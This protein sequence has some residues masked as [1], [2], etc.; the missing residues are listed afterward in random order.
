MNIGIIGGGVAGLTAAYE[1]TRKGHKVS[2]FEASPY[3]GGQAA[4]FEVGGGRLEKAYHHLFKSD[5]VIIDLIN[6][7][8]LG[9]KLYWLDSKVGFYCKERIHN[10][11]TPFD[12]L[13]FTPISIV[14]RLRLGLVSL[15]LQRLNDW[16]KLEG[17]TA[18][19]WII[20]YAGKQNYDMVWGPL[21]RGKFGD[22]AEEVGMVW[23]WG[24][25]HLRF[26]SRGKTM[27]KEKLGYLMGSFGQVIDALEQEIRKRGGEIHI[28][29]P[30]Q[31]IAVADGRVMGLELKASSN[32][33]PFDAVIATVPSPI[34]LRL[35]PELPEQY[36]SKL[37]QIKYQAAVL[38]V[39]LLKRSLSHIYWLNVS[40][41]A[42]P[43]LAAI[44]HTNY[45]GRSE[46]GGKHIVYLSNYLAREHPIYNKSGDELLQ[47]YL[48][49]LRKLNPEFSPDWI[50]KYYYH[51]ED[52]AQPIITT[53]YS[54]KIPDYRT[55]IQG[56]YLANTTQ[57][58]PEDRGMNYSIRLGQRVSGIVAPG[59]ER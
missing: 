31:R 47:I 42:L 52:S 45:I 34:F 56:L 59:L 1:L 9:S 39:L 8:G 37:R 38:V 55:P 48:P 12:L 4:T 24:K 3:L 19:D 18:K 11:V 21:L 58:Y 30:V 54:A 50:E 27:Q 16:P 2:I 49:H 46:Y 57:I 22:A 43:F 29:T 23:F 7:L 40:D 13:K 25:I 26:G 35:V 14:D 51:R 17:I 53:N 32:P 15:Y 28:S 36:A 10:F 5:T 20:K 6:E 33:V 44:E 41:R